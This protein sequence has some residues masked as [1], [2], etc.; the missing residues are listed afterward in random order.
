[1]GLDNEEVYPIAAKAKENKFLSER[2]QQI[3]RNLDDAIEVFNQLQP[4]L[5]QHEFEL[6]KWIRNND[7]VTEDLNSISYT[8]Q[9]WVEPNAEGSSRLEYNGLSLM[10]VFKCAE[11]QTNKLEHL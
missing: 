6:K 4:L 5:P 7:A 8:K 1:M 11:V 2:F 9:V 3:S 10:I